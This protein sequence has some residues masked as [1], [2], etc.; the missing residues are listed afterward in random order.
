MQSESLVC[1]ILV[2]GLL[3]ITNQLCVNS[4][5]P[6]ECCLITAITSIY[7]DGFWVLCLTYNRWADGLK[8]VL[9]PNDCLC[10]SENYTCLVNSGIAIAWRAKMANRDNLALSLTDDANES[11]IVAERGTF[12]YSC[13]TYYKLMQVGV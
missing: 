11:S 1:A 3:V 9:T 2:V 8:P 10:P 12:H 13:M 5:H 4:L 6:A 7:S